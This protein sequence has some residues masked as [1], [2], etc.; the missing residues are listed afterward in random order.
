LHVK[1]GKK[2][3]QVI[4]IITRIILITRGCILSG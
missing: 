3:E 4:L 1:I 2:S